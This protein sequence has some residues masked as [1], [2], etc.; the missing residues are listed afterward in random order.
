MSLN[1][2]RMKQFIKDS[3]PDTV[4]LQKVAFEIKIVDLWKKKVKLSHYTAWR[5]LGGEE[6]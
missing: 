5:R 3:S 1:I 2:L 6:I 4:L